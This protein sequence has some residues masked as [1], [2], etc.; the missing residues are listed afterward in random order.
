MDFR[1][2]NTASGGALNGLFYCCFFASPVSLSMGDMY[3]GGGLSNGVVNCALSS[4]FETPPKDFVKA[5]LG[6]YSSRFESFPLDIW[7]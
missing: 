1:P 5:I 3:S 7:D 4:S 2:G 6:L